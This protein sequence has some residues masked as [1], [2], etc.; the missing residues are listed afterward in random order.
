MTTS[1]SNMGQQYDQIQKDLNVKSKD[2][3]KSMIKERKEPIAKKTFMFFIIAIVAFL[4]GVLLL[5]PLIV[6]YKIDFWK[7][8]GSTEMSSVARILSWVFFALIIIFTLVGA[9]VLSLFFSSRFKMR[10]EAYK[11]INFDETLSTIF[12]FNNITLKSAPTDSN[13]INIESCEKIVEGLYR[14]EDKMVIQNSSKVIVLTDKDNGNE[15]T[16]QEAKILKDN[17]IQETALVF[18]CILKEDQHISLYGMYQSESSKEA[19]QKLGSEF[20]K[21][22]DELDLYA[23]S[24][25]V[26]KEKINEL[27]DFSKEF[28]LIQNKFGFFYNAQKQRIY[29][30][31]NTQNELFSV[32]NSSDV[33]ST[34]LNHAW[35]IT[36]IML[37]TS[38]LI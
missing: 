3:F 14:P 37:H 22:D 32:K 2:I 26:N 1:T 27:K 28:R 19:I 31:L 23:T 24:D 7:V 16:I 25:L 20:V 5:V 9:Y 38:A 30:W 8:A 21:L 18:E 11:K 13:D 6:I 33:T 29:I 12:N 10:Q 34:L 4:I 15:W 36:Q 35:L 17:K